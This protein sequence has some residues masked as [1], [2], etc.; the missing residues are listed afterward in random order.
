MSKTVDYRQKLRGV[1]PPIVTPF[2]EK[3]RFVREGIA[4]VVEFTIRAGAHGMVVGG[5]TGEGHTL[6]TR[7]LTEAVGA[8]CEAAKG[9]VPVLAGLIVNSTEMAIERARQFQGMGVAALQ[10]TPVHYLFKPD[11]DAT[12][13]HFKAIAEETGL[14]V[15]I[16]NV[17]PWN[18]LSA[19]LMLRIMDEV[20]GVIGMKQSNGDLKSLSDL[21]LR[22]KPRNIVVSGIDALLYPAFSLGAHGA[23][24]ALTAAVPGVIVRLWDLVKAGEHERAKAIHFKLNALWNTIRHDNLPACTKYLQHRQGISLYYPRPPMEKVTEAQ[25]QAMDGPLADLLASV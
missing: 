7:E 4:E 8:A 17:I 13:A 10:V 1:L 22:I 16:Y 15:I 11:A 9:R 18:Y 12:V 14:P 6:T 21:L 23:I 20:P 3:G 25:K 2:D 19:D 24:T 5:S